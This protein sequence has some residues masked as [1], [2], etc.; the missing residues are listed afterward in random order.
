MDEDDMEGLW[1]DQT[2]PKVVYQADD[3]DDDDGMIYE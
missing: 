3:D 2:R 1:R